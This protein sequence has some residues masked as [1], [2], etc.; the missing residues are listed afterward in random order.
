MIADPSRV[1]APGSGTAARE[2]ERKKPGGAGC[3]VNEG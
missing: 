3:H 2:Q 1:R